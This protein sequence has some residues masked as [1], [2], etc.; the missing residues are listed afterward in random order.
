MSLQGYVNQLR[1]RKESY[2][3]HVDK[4]KRYISEEMTPEAE[5][6]RAIELVELIDTKV[7]TIDAQTQLKETN[8][9]RI[10][11]TQVVNDKDRIKFAALAKEIIDDENDFE[12]I[13]ITSAR[14]EKDYHFRHNSVDRSIYVQLKPSGAKGQVRD[15][16]NELLS[17]I[18]ACLNYNN[19]TN[20]EELDILID[21][22][23]N[24]IS[25]SQGHTEGQIDLFD[26][27]YTNACQAISA[28]N[29]MKEMLGGTA[30]QVFMTGVKWPD[31]VSQFKR[32]A[33]GMKDFNSSDIIL[34]KGKTYFGISLK[35]KP[36]KS[37]EDPTILNKA[38][39][40]IL[41]GPELASIKEELLKK[42]E[43]FYIRVIKQAMKDK[44]LNT[45]NVNAKNWK[46]FLGG[47]KKGTKTK[48]GNDYVNKSLKSTSSHF[49]DMADIIKSNEK[50]IAESLVNLVLKL[51]LKDLQDNN[52]MFSLITGNGRY[53]PKIGAV[54]D[55]AD[56]YD[57]QTVFEKMDGLGWSERNLSIEFN[58][59]KIQA[60]DVG[61]TAAKLFYVVKVG[62][63]DILKIELRYKGSFT[64]QPQ[65]FAVFTNKFKNLLK[66]S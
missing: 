31:E 20:I 28:A 33:Y 19:P 50:L 62:K 66:S 48:L 17:G 23:K 53:G 55:D 59:R 44:V 21:L 58:N 12:N 14:A 65:F 60:F 26:K 61:A 32:E 49:K 46:T 25:K 5:V 22:A 3:N 2:V 13:V 27:A 64:A 47:G 7:A 38:F 43:E 52:F 8:K 54:I 63:M 29:A 24:N 15:D 42:K 39:D 57:I 45:K 9:N 37:A 30:D 41:N 16:P 40:S 56:V 6:Q 11:I 4:I 51:D 18:F 34:K 35:K 36:S 10:V 1:P